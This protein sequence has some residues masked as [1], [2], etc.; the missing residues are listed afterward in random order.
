M[1]IIFFTNMVFFVAVRF[2]NLFERMYIYIF[3]AYL[4][5]F[6]VLLTYWFASMIGTGNG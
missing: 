6:F 5:L 1:S 4:T 2:L 3:G